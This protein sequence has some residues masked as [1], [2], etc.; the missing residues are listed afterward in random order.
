MPPFTRDIAMT[1]LIRPDLGELLSQ[2]KPQAGEERSAMTVPIS[3][4]DPPDDTMLFEAADDPARRFH[5]P[6]YRIAT[7]RAGTGD[8]FRVRFAQ[9]AAGATLEVFLEPFVPA[10]LG[11]TAAGTAPLD[12]VVSAVLVF[13]P[14][15]L[16]GV[17]RELPFTE[18]QRVDGLVRLA[19]TVPTATETSDLYWALTRPE[20]R[21]RLLVRRLIDVAVPVVV[22]A[23]RPRPDRIDVIATPPV[24]VFIDPTVHIDP[25]IF[26]FEPIVQQDP[27]HDPDPTVV[28]RADP[29]IL[30]PEVLQPDVLQPQ[31]I[32]Q[33][34]VAVLNQRFAVD[35]ITQLPSFARFGALGL[36]PVGDIGEL[37]PVRRRIP[38]RVRGGIDAGRAVGLPGRVDIDPV[39]IDPVVIGPVVVDPVRPPTTVTLY[40]RT[41]RSL[42]V[43]PAPQPFVFSPTLHDYVFAGVAPSGAPGA[44]VLDQFEFE[45]TFHSYYRSSGRPEIAYFLPDGFKLARLPQRPR[46]PFMSVQ[47]DSTDGTIEQATATVVLAA[48]AWT[49][50]ERLA[51]AAARLSRRIDG[52]ATHVDLQPLIA[53]SSRLSLRLALPGEDAQDIPSAVIDLRT[54]LRT[55]IEVPLGRFQR[56]FDA[57]QG[58]GAAV[59]TGEVEVR[60]DHPDRPAEKVPFEARFDDLAGDA[61][62]VAVTSRPDGTGFDVSVLNACE[63][64]LR[65]DAATART[66]TG[67]VAVEGMP[68]ADAPPLAPA[69]QAGLRVAAS[70]ETPVV[71]VD[72]TV[73]PDRAAIW[74]AVCDETTSF[75]QRQVT[76]RTPAVMFDAAQGVI[77]VTVEIGPAAGGLTSTVTLRPD[78]LET[79]AT[80]PVPFGDVVVEK[81]DAGSYRYR[82]TAVRA[83]RVTEGD[84]KTRTAG[85][86]WIVTGDVA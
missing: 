37:T 72:V 31:V 70:G 42:E 63:S 76:V 48:A 4:A 2:L 25:R 71:D 50:P 52:G 59:L 23:E 26:R 86:L 8:Q 20:N 73:L 15:E 75:L 49:D 43:V 27:L 82:V 5:L 21:A 40:R 35:R 67:P 19:L 38:G 69:A 9:A 36:G 24:E 51:D 68:P 58:G 22:T 79:V 17:R 85:V 32:A 18:V 44:L 39:V 41:T 1:K 62:D 83:D 47:F 34:D 78:T 30:Q 53:D 81:E 60:L 11:D 74:D 61:V 13:E 80:V 29:V 45:G 64:P 56:L 12:H 46:S 33:P 77:E 84:W 55:G 66:S 28:L 54:V 6:T 14:A 65:I 3:P 57:L 16:A 7:V 10:S